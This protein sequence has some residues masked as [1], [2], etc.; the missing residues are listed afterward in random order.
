MS[1]GP[2]T[3][4]VGFRP[5]D[6]P[7]R[8]IGIGAAVLVA[9][10]ALLTMFFTVE[11]EEVGVVLRFGKY[12]R[13]V[14]P[15]L[16][17]KMPFP[18]EQVAKVA[19]ERQ[20]KQEYGFRTERAGI[21]TD[22]SRADF[23]KESLMLTGDLNVAEVEWT[24]QY[25]VADPYRWLFKV[26]DIEA[27]FRLMNE[28]VMREVVG[29]RSVNEVITVGRE[30]IASEVERR[31]QV[32]CEQYDTGIE[33]VQI[34]L[35]NVTPPDE[36]K[37]SFNEVNQAQQER[38]RMINEARTEYNKVIPKARGEALRAIQEAEGYKADR[39]NRSKGDAAAFDA[40]L[41][42]Y[43]RAPD[44]TRRRIYLETMQYVYPRV[45]TKIVLDK[46]VQGVLPLIDLEGKK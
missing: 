33:V 37:P 24:T 19:A 23:S 5:P 18:I 41:A 7:F 12:D 1:G 17:V 44:V 42:A 8:L 21:R 35:Q 14:E 2:R 28:A 36:V 16:H 30:E 10:L 27:T 39:V 26:R 9:V 6:I 31:L 13:T 11:P 15:G 46:D 20:L 43:R 45:K 29:D 25:R 32:L 38:E 3:V 22:Y 34:V 4:Q 40:L